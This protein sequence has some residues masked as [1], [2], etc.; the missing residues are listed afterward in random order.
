MI[1]IEGVLASQWIVMHT[2]RWLE[3]ACHVPFFKQVFVHH[4]SVWFVELGFELLLPI[5]E[6][7]GL[8]LLAQASDNSLAILCRQFSIFWPYLQFALEGVMTV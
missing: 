5:G 4:V 8:L 3:T 1:V 7:V 2:D 6:W